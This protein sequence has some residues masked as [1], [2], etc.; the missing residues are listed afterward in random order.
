MEIGKKPLKRN[1]TE[2][3]REIELDCSMMRDRDSAHAYLKEKMGF[4]AYY[5]KNLDALFDCLYG[6][7]PCRVRVLN[8]ESLSD[9]GSYG[10]ALL[11][12]FME[13]A[14]KDEK[15]EFYMES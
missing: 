4:P 5:G 12:V 10:T 2:E 14:E 3:I 13:I 6:Y 11:K 7:P 8:K 1:Q 9:L 15:F